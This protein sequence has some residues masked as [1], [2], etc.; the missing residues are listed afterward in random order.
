MEEG[1]GNW[2]GEGG[3]VLEHL[4]VDAKV[5]VRVKVVVLARQVLFL[6]GLLFSPRLAMSPHRAGRRSILWGRGPGVGP[7]LNGGG[8]CGLGGRR[9]RCGLG[10]PLF[11]LP[12]LLVRWHA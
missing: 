3:T 12:A 10:G 11:G 7:V 9:S 1:E 2:G 8:S 5:R 6:L 4:L